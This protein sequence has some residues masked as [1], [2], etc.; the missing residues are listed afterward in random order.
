MAK[1]LNGIMAFLAALHHKTALVNFLMATTVKLEVFFYKNNQIDKF[2]NTVFKV[3]S[4]TTKN[5]K[6]KP[7]FSY[8]AK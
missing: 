1:E 4:F 2:N 5:F 8:K 3:K 7:R 6:H